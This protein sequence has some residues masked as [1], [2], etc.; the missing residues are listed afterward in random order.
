MKQNK[1]SLILNFFALF[2]VLQSF[3]IFHHK[4]FSCDKNVNYQQTKSS[5]EII[6]APLSQRY[7][8]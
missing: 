2:T 7:S 6:F 8:S 3:V 4:V 1:I 5:E